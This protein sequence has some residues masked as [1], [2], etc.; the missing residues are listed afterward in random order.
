MS[1]I[2]LACRQLSQNP[3]FTA[4]ALLSLA[5]GIGANTAIFSL[6]NDFLLR[7]LPVAHPD[8]LVLL[9]N[10]EGVHGRISRAGENNGSVDPVTGRSA[11]TSF[12]LLMLERMQAD[13][14]G[15]A[16]VFAFAP[17]SQVNV[18]VDGQPELDVSAQLVS[19][20]YYGGLGV[21]A[22]IGR[23]LNAADDRIS[24]EPAAVISYR[25]W[26]R[27]FGGDPSVLGRIL[28]VNRIAVPIVGVTAQGFDG[29]MQ[30]GESPDLSV[31]LA[32]H[33]RFQPD[34]VSRTQ[35]WYWWIRV[36][37]RLAPGATPPQAAAALEPAFQAAAREGWLAGPPAPRALARAQRLAR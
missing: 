2:R 9:R 15:L 3:G 23:T 5:I 27:R 21:P 19:G 10:V 22:L 4:V 11:S 34:R 37:G 13:H 1:D 7:E 18:L 28:H 20:D 36:M 31:P 24:A 12:S 6:V 16:D 32:Q 25:F 14:P 35:P 8:E 33:L 30:A 17:F 26:Q 29:T